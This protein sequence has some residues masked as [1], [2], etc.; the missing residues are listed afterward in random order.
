LFKTNTWDNENEGIYYDYNLLDVGDFGDDLSSVK[1]KVRIYGAVIDGVQFIYTAQ[2]TISQG[3]YGTRVEIID[4]ENISDETQAKEVGDYW[5]SHLKDPVTVGEV[6][7]LFLANL[8]PGQRIW[9]AS[10]ADTI[11]DGLYQIQSYKHEIDFNRS[12]TTTVNVEKKPRTI[13]HVLSNM[14]QSQQ[15]LKQ[16][17]L[18]PEDMDYSYIFL[19]NTDTGTHDKTEITSGLLQLQAG[20]SSGTWISGAKNTDADVTQCYIVAIGTGLDNATIYVSSDNGL[21]WLVCG[22]KSLASILSN[23]GRNLRVKVVISSASTQVDSL[24]VMYK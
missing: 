2:D 20:Q 9:V 11:N 14:I 5:L 12:L 15:D 1:N 13:S 23:Y 10:P 17:S 18:N 6:K 21:N 24:A 7:G 4:D 8:F 3:L 19:F 22:N 16:V